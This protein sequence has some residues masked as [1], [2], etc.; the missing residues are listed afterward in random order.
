[1]WPFTRKKPPEE[2]RASG[3]GYTAEILAAR[4][5]YIS[6]RSGIAELTGTAQA[7]VTLWEGG[8]AQAD[9]TGTDLLDGRTLALAGRSLAL[10][11][12][13]VFLIRPDGLVPC[14]DWDLTTRDGIPRAYRV[15]VSEAGGGRTQA[16]LAAEVLHLRIGC[17]PA[18][19]Y[20]GTAPLRRA[21]ITAGLLNAVE[22][23]LSEIYESAPLGSTVLHLPEGISGDLGEVSHKLLGRRGRVI[24]FEGV[25]TAIAGGMA[26]NAHKSPD[27]LTPDLSKA[28]TR[29][30]WAAARDSIAACF[31]VLPGL[32]NP[33]TTGPMVREAQ[34]HLAQWMLQPIAAQIAQEASTKLGG[35]V[36]LDVTR[37]LQS[38]D[39]G[40]RARALGA[41][42]KAMAEAQAAGIDPDKALRLVDWQDKE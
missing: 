41:I 38:F 19:P 7:C 32:L 34:R 18:A 26:P 4:E 35:T 29:E 30:T 20:L 14:S 5:S 31:G 40:G 10:R 12:D 37:P 25:Q 3:S 13:V 24:A 9:V 6:G 2:T 15:S 28:M 27:G 8:L 21:S 36:T 23:A 16:V 42:I 17:D 22:S 1:M 11:G 39:T 33:A